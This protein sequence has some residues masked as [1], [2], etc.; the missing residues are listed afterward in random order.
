[1]L[2]LVDARSG[3]IVGTELLRPVP[4]FASM[5]EQEL[6][7]TILKEFIRLKA[8]PR[9]IATRSERMYKL[10]QPLAKELGFKLQR[11]QHLPTLD[12]V[13]MMMESMM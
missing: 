8:L 11:R 1:M 4:S 12:A 7:T 6:P 9:A 3:M 2:L 10:L 5:V 13:R